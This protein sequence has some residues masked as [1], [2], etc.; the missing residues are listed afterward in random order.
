MSLTSSVCEPR[1]A[2]APASQSVVFVLNRDLEMRG[3]LED[4]IELGGWRVEVFAAPSD[5]LMRRKV[6]A[7]SCL[8]LDVALQDQSGLDLQR[9][10]A[11]I[12]KTVPLVFVSRRADI[13]TTVQAMKAGAVDFLTEPL[14]EEDVLEAVQRGLDRSRALRQQ[15][16]EQRQL[17]A[18]YQSLTPR[19]RQVM[20]L[21]TSGLLNKQVAGELGTSE[22]TV[23][24]QRGQVMRK[25]AADSLAALVR[26]AAR[27]DLPLPTYH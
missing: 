14:R 4:L 2:T 9:Q 12:E 6:D 26:M 24:A 10:L 15:D 3:F 25:M 8:V 11:V 22:I 13:L 7:P 23:K 16:E 17:L 1:S 19:E 27:L 20:A 21:V 18:R 5:F